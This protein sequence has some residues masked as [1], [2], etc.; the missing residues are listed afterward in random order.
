VGRFFRMALVAI[1][2]LAV[3]VQ[4]GPVR[5][6]LVEVPCV[7][8]ADETVSVIAARFHV[9]M[10]DLALLNE[11]IDLS[12]VAPGTQLVVGYAERVEH[13]VERGETLLRLGRRYGVSV[14]D[15]TRWNSIADASRVRAGTTLV[16][17]VRPSLPPSASVGR[18][19]DG[20]LER[21]VR[22]RPNPGWVVREPARAYVTRDVESWMTDGF[23]QVAERFPRS[24]RIEVRDASAEHG[25]RLREHRSHQTGRDIDLVYYQ[26]QCHGTCVFHRVSAREL[27][28]ERQWALLEAWLRA[29]VVEYVFIDHALQEPLYQ[30]ALAAGARR[31][32]LSHWFQWP[33]P[34]DERFGIVRHVRGHRDHLHVRFVCAAH[35]RRCQRATGSQDEHEEE[36]EEAPPS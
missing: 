16:I 31:E 22:L 15:I 9:S 3:A 5:A 28:A 10:D 32:E 4:P 11:G 13:R 34:A 36:A 33:R 24:A 27:D 35:D 6:E 30:A 1:S 7:V 25:G 2:L 8:G 23:A 20:S 17:Y 29:G 12:S 26:R 21:G 19:N 18:P 14:D